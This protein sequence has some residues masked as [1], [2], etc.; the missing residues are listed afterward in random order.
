MVMAEKKKVHKPT[1]PG[2]RPPSEVPAS[3]G[4]HVGMNPEHL[5]EDGSV[6]TGTGRSLS[7]TSAN[8]RAMISTYDPSRGGVDATGKAIGKDYFANA[9]TLL[10]GVDQAAQ[11]LTV[12]GE[13]VT[14]VADQGEQ[15]ERDRANVNTDPA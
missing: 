12:R 2:F 7:A 1:D 14:K 13:D 9:S 5:R 8:L 11:I 15:S 4:D 3:S 6:L 10:D